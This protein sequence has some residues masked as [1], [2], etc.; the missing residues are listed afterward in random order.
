[1]PRAVIVFGGGIDSA[2]ALAI[3]RKRGFE[4]FAL[5]IDYGQRHRFEVQA[6]KKTAKLLGAV[7]HRVVSID[8]A[9]L[10][11]SALTRD[12]I[13]VPDYCDD[14]VIHST[15]VPARNSIFLSIA[16]GWAESLGAYT[17][18]TGFNKADYH[19]FPDCTAEYV[20]AFEQLATVSTKAGNEGQTFSLVTPLIE[21]NKDDIIRCGLELGVDF[22]QTVTCY[23]A[24]AE[25]RACGRC[26]SCVIRRKGFEAAKVADPTRYQ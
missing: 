21:K 6:A 3:M 26:D 19:G 7:S 8:L 22:S 4:C 13:S 17:L 14:Q 2:V 23:A 5:T 1:M 24:D 20:Q 11:D 12:D 9:P 10:L 16:L 25:G 15:Y 18:V